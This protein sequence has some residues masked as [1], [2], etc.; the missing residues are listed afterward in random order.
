MATAK[1]NQ[2][3]AAA[4]AIAAT[5]ILPGDPAPGM[6]QVL[7]VI[8]KRDG[9]RRAGREWHGTTFVPVQELTREQ[10]EQID[11]EP[12]LVAQLMEVPE[13]QAGELAARDGADG[14]ETGT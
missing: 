14:G 6:R 8:S 7:Q 4:A 5:A 11:R 12:M 3:L 2:T 13:E 9:F 10:F 1:K